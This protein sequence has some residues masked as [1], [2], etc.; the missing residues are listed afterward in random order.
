MKHR[1]GRI[2]KI[3]YRKTLAPIQNIPTSTEDK[4]KEMTLDITVGRKTY[5]ETIDATPYE[6]KLRA[7]EL[8]NEYH[9]TV[10]VSDRIG[11]TVVWVMDN[12]KVNVYRR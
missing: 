6:A 3:D 12:G 2:Q 9:E 7:I 11:D 1:N 5:K 8:Y 4:E 10:D